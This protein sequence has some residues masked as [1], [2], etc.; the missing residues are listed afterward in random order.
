MNKKEVFTLA[1]GGW[2]KVNTPANGDLNFFQIKE[3]DK[4]T[5]TKVSIPSV[6]K[7]RLM[8]SDDAQQHLMQN[9]LKLISTKNAISLEYLNQS[10]S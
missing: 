5:D 4:P 6:S 9:L 1:L 3:T 8:L 2:T 10:G 7:A